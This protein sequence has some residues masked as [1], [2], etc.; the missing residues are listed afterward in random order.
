MKKIIFVLSLLMIPFTTAQAATVVVG[1][2]NILSA[3][4]NGNG[5]LLVTQKA[6][7]SQTATLQSLSFYITSAAGKMRLGIYDAT[8]PGGGPGNKK[9]ETNEITPV[10]GWNTANVTSAVSLP[11]GTYWLAYFPSDNRLAFKKKLTGSAKYYS[12]T[13]G[14]L[15]AKFSTTP[16]SEVVHWSLYA[17]FSTTSSADKTPPNVSLTAPANG[18]S[19]SGSSVT[20]SANAS[21]NVGV[22]GVQFKLDG[23]N[24][25]AEDTSSPYSITM[26]STKVSNGVHSLTAVARDSAEN[27]KTSSAV[28]ITVNNST[29]ISVVISG[30]TLNNND[31]LGGAIMTLTNGDSINLSNLPTQNIN[32][33]AKVTSTG[34][35]VSHVDFK[36]DSFT[37]TEVSAPYALCGDW[38]A[39][40]AGLFSVGSHTLTVTP[41][42]SANAAG[43]TTTITF[44]VIKTTPPPSDTTPPTVSMTAP[45]NN[46]S[47]SGSNVTVSANASDDVGVVGVQFKL[48]G[49]TL[50]AEDTSSPYFIIWDAT[51]T[52]NGAHTLTATARDAAGNSKT[53]SVVNVT[54]NNP[55]TTA[56]SAPTGLMAKVISTSEIDLSWN[57]STDNVGVTG[58]NI[59]RNNQLIKTQ[60]TLALA[61][62]GLTAST[63]YA[64]GVSAIDAAGNESAKTTVSAKTND[65]QAPVVSPI[66]RDTADV[67]PATTG[68][69]FYEGTTVTYSSSATDPDNDPLTWSWIYTRNGGAE[70]VFKT[71]TGAV[72]NA[73]FT[74]PTG[75]A[76]TTYHWILRVSDGIHTVESTLDVSI[77]T[78]P[79]TTAPTVSMT[80]PANNASVS[81]SSITVSANASD[82]AGVIGVQFKMDGNTYGAEDM[83]SPYSIVMDSTKVSNGAHTL[84]ATA[85][86][87]VGNSTT[88]SVVNITVSNDLTAPTVSISAPANNASV[89]GSSVTVSANA[90]DNVGVVGVQFKLDGNN[91][92]AE[93][94]ASPYSVILDS[95]KISNASHTLTA[96]ARDAAGNSTTSST[97]TITVNNQPPDTTPPTVSMTAPANNASVSGASVTVSANTSDNVG[98]VGVQFILDSSNLGAEDTTSPY[99]VVLDSTKI[100][101]GAHTLK[102]VARDAAGN[103]GTSSIVNIM[104]N[105]QVPDTTPPTVS[106]TA[107]VNNATVSGSSVIVSANASDTVGVVG[108]QFKLDGN[109]LGSEDTS[110][111]YSINF[112]S[113]TAANGSHTL[114]AVARDAA[115][116][117]T[118]SS[119][120]SITVSNTTTPPPTSPAYPLKASANKRYL[121]DQNNQPVF[122]VGDS[123]HAMFVNLST[124]Q[125]ATYMTNRASYGVN[126]L[127]VEILCGSYIPNCRSDMSTFDGIVPFTTPGDIS[128]PNPAYFSRIDAMVAT[129]A[130]NGII[131]FIDTWE[132]GGEMG[133]LQANGNTKA[134]NY[135]V[136][137]G[138]RYKN[139]PN[140]IW[141]TG[142]DF[143]TSGNST[144]DTL[145]KNI[146]AGIASV[147][148]NHLQT[149]QL[150]YPV[151]GSHE[152]SLLLPYITL[153]EVYS[154]PPQ[155]AKIY[156]EYNASPTL[157]VYMEEANY[158]GENNTG[159]DPSTPKVLRQQEYWT[160]LAGGLAGQM[161]GS[162]TTAY[163]N[164]GWQN[165]LDT[166]G[167][168]QL[169][170]MKN[171]FMAYGWQNLVPDQNHTFVT[172]G[173]GTF[174]NS[175]AVHTNDY[176][177]A[178]VSPDGTLG[179]VYVPSSRTMTVAMTKMASTTVTARWFD[180]SNG[181]YTPVSGSPFANTGTKQ[182]TPPGNNS[183]G[184]SDWVLVLQSSTTPDNQAPSVPGN[185]TANAVSSNQINLS[186]KSSTDNVG[187]TNY[188]IFRNGIQI[189]TPTSTT[190]QDTG[191][192]AQ[193]TYIYTVAAQDLMGNTSAQSASASATTPTAPPLSAGLLAAY[194]FDETSG[195]TAADSSGNNLPGTLNGSATWTAG[196]YS[197]AVNLNGSTQYVDLGNPASLQLTG[198]MTV[199]A[200]IN[201]AAFPADDAAVVSKRNTTGGYQLDTTIDVGP[202]AIGFKLTDSSGVNMMRYGKTTM[203]TNTW[204]HVA[205]VYNAATQTMDVYL[206]GIL[207]NGTLSGTI[208][209]TQQDFATNVMI[210]KRSG[211]SGYEFNGRIDNVRI[212]NRA[213]TAAEIQTDMNTAIIAGTLPPPPPSSDAT[214]P[215]VPSGLTATAMSASQVNLSW[216][217]STD[218]LGVTG[219]KVY[220]CQGAGCSTFAQVGTS[221]TASYQDTGL[222]AST[223]YSYKV[224]AYDAA[225]NLSGY[226]N[227]A[228]GTTPGS[229]T[230]GVC[231]RG[232]IIM[233]ENWE[234]ST[235][236]S[237]AASASDWNAHGWTLGET[238]S[239][240][241][242]SN[243]Y[244]NGIGYAGNCAAQLFLDVDGAGTQYPDYPIPDQQGTIYLRFYVKYSPGY[245]FNWNT[246]VQPPE[247]EQQKVAYLRALSGGNMAWRIEI[248]NFG[249]NGGA[250]GE[251]G[252]DLNVHNTFLKYNQGHDVNV[253]GGQWYAI[254]L[255]AQLNTP[256]QTN[257]A[258]KMWIDG[259]L[260]IS[261]SGLDMRQGA[262]PASTP[263]NDVWFTSYYGG[264]TDPHPA[265]YIYYDNFVVSSNYIGPIGTPPPSDTTA[266]TISLTAPANNAT[267]SGSSVS[268]SANASDNVGVAGVQF[269]LDGNNLGSE[270]ISS[271][272]SVVWN[273]TTATNGSHTLTAVARDA[274]GNTTT[275]TSA[276]VTVNN[277][278]ADTTAPT[279][280]MT[281]P[282]NGVTVSGS[283]VPVSANASDN[284]SVAGVQFVLDGNNLGNEDTSSPYSVVWNSTTAT[285]GS[286]TLTAIAR[287]AAGNIATASSVTV[288][289]NNTVSDT[290][291]PSVPTGLNA[292]ALSSSQINLSWSS[293]TD[294]VGVTGYKI[295]RC[296]GS[297]CSTFTQIGTSTTAAYQDNGLSASTNY[298]YKVSAYDTA[299]N[300][301]AQSASV[302]ATTSSAPTGS[303]S[304]LYPGDVG[305]ENDPAVLFTE[306]FNGGTLSQIASRYDDVSNLSSMTLS[307]DVP[308]GSGSS[309]SL[310]IT[311]TGGQSSG[312]HLYKNLANINKTE[313]DT[314]YLRYYVKYKS[315]FTFHHNSV[316][317]GGYNPPLNY[318]YPRA[319]LKPAGNDLF[320][321]ATEPVEASGRL[322]NYIYW[323]GMHSDPN[324][325]YWGNDL[326]QDANLKETPDQWICVETMV[327]LNNPVTAANGELAFW[328]NGQ[329]KNDLG[330]GFPN[331]HWVWDSF[332][333]TATD[334]TTFGGFQWR[335]DA[336]LN[337]NY[338]WIQNYADTTPVGSTSQMEVANLVAAKQYIGCLTSTPPPSDTT[339]PSVPSG[340]NA[341]AISSSQINLSWGASTDNVGVTGYKVYRC[342]GSSCST[343][344]QV[345]TSATTNYQDSGLNA[346]T[347]YSYK[348]SAYDAAGNNS[349]QSNSTNATTQSSTTA[350]NP[351]CS[352]P[353]VLY[354]QDWTNGWTGV[355]GPADGSCNYIDTSQAHSATKS[356]VMNWGP[357]Q[358]SCSWYYLPTFTPQ[359][360]VYVRWYQYMS[361][362]WNCNDPAHESKDFIINSARA[363]STDG[364]TGVQIQFGDG[365]FGQCG[366]GF[367]P[368][369]M[370]TQWDMMFYQNQGHDVDFAANP[371]KWYCIE[372]HVK[373]NDLNQSNAI[374]EAWVDNTLVMKH[375][376]MDLSP[377]DDSFMQLWGTGSKIN[378]S[379]SSIARWTDDIVI[380][381][382]RIGCQNASLPPPSSD[383]VPPTVSLTAPTNNASLSGTSVTVSANASDNIGVAGVQFKLDGN[384]LGS[385]VTSSPYS[386]NWNSTTATNGSHILTAVAHDAAGNT[387]TSSPVTVTVSNQSSSN[388][389][390]IGEQ[391][392]LTSADNGNG[393]LLVAQSATLPQTAM[394]NSLSFYVT[395][396]AGK[397]RLGIYDA[398]GPNGGPGAKK[399]ETN[400]M[401]PVV[402]WNTAN[403]TA[404]SLPAGTYWL[405]Y[406]ASDDNL[407]FVK[408]EDSSSS[409]AYYSYTYGTLPS[410]FSTS[411]STT[412]S[413]WSFDATLS[414][415]NAPPPPSSDTTAPSVP[416]GLTASA[417]SSSQIN[418]SWSASTDNIGVTGYK[419]YRCQGSGCSAF[420]QVGTSPTT[421]YQD[422]GLTAST[423]YSYKVS[424]Y[425]AAGNN[426]AT[427]SSVSSTT[428]AANSTQTIA[429][430][431]WNSISSPWHLDHGTATIDSS[432]NTPNPTGALHFVYP[433]GWHDGND[434]GGVN[435]ENFGNYNELY[436]GYYFKYS[437]NFQWHPV[438]NKHAYVW[439]GGDPS[440]GNF[441]VAVGGNQHMWFTNQIG[442]GPGSIDYKP[443]TAN[444]PTIQAGTW[445]WMEFHV[446]QNTPGQSDGLFEMWIN[447]QLVMQYNNI[448]YRSSSQSNMGFG[449]F[450]YTPVWGGVVGATNNVQSDLWVDHT[451]ISTGPIGVPGATFQSA[452]VY[453]N[454]FESADMRPSITFNGTYWQVTGASGPYWGATPLGAGEEPNQ[455]AGVYTA[456][457]NLGNDGAHSP[458]Y[459][460]DSSLCRT[461]S[462]L[463]YDKS[464]SGGGG[465]ALYYLTLGDTLPNQTS[466]HL[467]YRAY[468][469]FPIGYQFVFGKLNYMRDYN[470]TT[471]IVLKGC[472][473]VCT[474]T[475]LRIEVGTP[476]TSYYCNQGISCT[477]T[478][479]NQW[480][481]LEVELDPN[482]G[483]TNAATIRMW[484]DSNL[485]L[486]YCPSC[487]QHATI[488][489]PLNPGGIAFGEYDNAAAEGG[490][491]P[492]QNQSFWL[493]D[494]A[495]SRQRIGP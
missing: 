378:Q 290:T 155:Y 349:T 21:D 243:V 460:N 318:P 266:P 212:Y 288:T 157:P 314:M 143:T 388:S 380:S 237:Y 146:M 265:Q 11:S 402:G 401:T 363:P 267:V 140:V 63:T 123:P 13:Y 303:L 67:D 74:Y 307:N 321:V 122:L 208:S 279:V 86:D 466:Q 492:T 94:T 50:S 476:S 325:D 223:N 333:P 431:D 276:M 220:R 245:K 66:S 9:A 56:P 353:G 241:A 46:S 383:A 51:K 324:G 474:S 360:E 429:T 394:I 109:N 459:V 240:Y 370:K 137:L 320:T 142:N 162:A 391:N 382:Q 413:H 35:G 357:N 343:F 273:S 396:A 217:T 149:V 169:K 16:N 133:I 376:G 483:G 32:I 10:V 406:L 410:T 262:G 316:W 341:T 108:V 255:M 332:Y 80:T 421:S 83:A 238:L 38:A 486:E 373:L 482:G 397:L 328:I 183:D 270:D 106:M 348:I 218:N 151:S 60:N 386:I 36:L 229:G 298:S 191:L 304:S 247:G 132:T 2:K 329:K 30:L 297:G 439:L 309:T 444:N 366:L 285:N 19:V 268:V 440:N 452:D 361:P 342:Q 493:D 64:Y 253:V 57:A 475:D 201:S 451:V 128:T 358:N 17:T 147:D 331:G 105:N 313:N 87:A 454:T 462:C 168:R 91:L 274:A 438:A 286:H 417:V 335:S 233:C 418:L 250:S 425:D 45:A 180:P 490:G 148:P 239:T 227:Q 488:A 387:T 120:V 294:N 235:N 317:F 470:G 107:P 189:A 252:V 287:D 445:Y 293:S 399:A 100:S 173:Y 199:T 196:K 197:G 167:V 119:A 55:D 312:G 427:S 59:Y 207:D 284:V 200:W 31:T 41:F 446:K 210:G 190:Y 258:I 166:T 115:G 400:E 18:A 48:D 491:S 99:S 436:V 368:I 477:I 248:D 481:S 428:S 346:S 188:V 34:T 23:N 89:S 160:M 423:S 221:A 264:P 224:S 92:G 211:N 377:G 271:P 419:V 319:G 453:Y 194:A 242:N 15:P 352:L 465:G 424:A 136:F 42:D 144:D 403:V 159:N 204:Y 389:L 152:D 131:L 163:F 411:P 244:C 198:S 232:D 97:I 125:A 141:I 1:E 351:D 487:S 135:G 61:D 156:T 65:N 415:T 226:S 161:Y 139:N 260:V 299:G 228:T 432:T 281:A 130:Q 103:L 310:L 53:S 330:L 322:D 54:V 216:S 193:T 49:N 395:N 295:F 437:S 327:K 467:F 114:T 22:A 219:Y 408:T 84:T 37:H 448:P 185:L 124:S 79:D 165:N 338:I 398:T 179:M 96:V 230:D 202:R 214:P 405:A 88:S 14:S 412:P 69:Q 443:N 40:P 231:N 337:L 374:I 251:F 289:V 393:N 494:L 33:E 222:S 95:T 39:C 489:T 164:S 249:R 326:L 472:S 27:T 344:T 422:T 280:S 3:D 170:I 209:S 480:H 311:A 409:G 81:G 359:K 282:I 484:R 479:D 463:R 47:V 371:T 182:F 256:G 102:A 434:P 407:A 174:A 85:R 153:G 449:S 234:W 340:L 365:N 93:D 458:V 306:K 392:V 12:L 112:D 275:S 5:N 176:A 347:N 118:T 71:G 442:W 455:P 441:F 468:Q 362:G 58:Y 186:W 384:N 305:I 315:G 43:Q 25:G 372:T 90:A 206:N 215:S 171:F 390:I 364:G 117:T 110:S 301:S 478:G 435:L 257:G 426:S 62:T 272:Y 430:N 254:E 277:V 461:Q 205:G 495:V 75:S 29:P 433:V 28:S 291:P 354:C 121:V 367:R 414:T 404:V 225:G 150:G 420:A 464:P 302:N 457:A 236:P 195:S 145:I 456:S 181:N 44:Q 350:V 73:V 471:V 8:G 356:N 98:V 4:D 469:K 447:G 101:N 68:L 379:N 172:A 283:S 473:P 213:L 369:R 116:N 178:A 78:P 323:M 416:T 385:E 261:N 355:D 7:L 154:Y 177:T 296:Q 334:S 259:V 485:V 72:Q 203:Q 129:A 24:L 134:F 126:A 76:G 269:K 20:V 127:W 450:S 111:P 104:V 375:T 77:I 184:D 26:D 300:N 175:G 52:S 278:P 292:A 113:T 339:P 70:V 192:T 82:N 246:S 187:V 336:N 158:E 138:N 6:T 308:A 345:G 381:T 263:I